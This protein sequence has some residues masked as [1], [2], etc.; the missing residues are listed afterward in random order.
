MVMSVLFSAI[1]QQ[2]WN[3]Y[4]IAVKIMIMQI[5]MDHGTIDYVGLAQ[6]H[7]NYGMQLTY[8]FTFSFHLTSF[9]VVLRVD[10]VGF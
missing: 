5:D 4:A 1:L 9:S 7:P 10:L 3:E 8:L 2:L 6:A